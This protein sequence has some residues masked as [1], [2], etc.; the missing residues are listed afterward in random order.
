MPKVLVHFDDATL[1]AIDRVA[2]A[3]KRQG[4]AF[5]RRAVKDALFRLETEQMREAYRAKPD[6][7]EGA[8][9]RELP[10]A[11]KE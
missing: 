8:E 11:W 3:G 2:P 9:N 10:E 5:V 4:A 6:S 1:K 7:A